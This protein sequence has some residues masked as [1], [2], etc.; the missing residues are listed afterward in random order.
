MAV[1]INIIA[2]IA[3]QTF[4][5]NPQSKYRMNRTEIDQQ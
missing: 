1:E 5:K 4:D 3:Y 2:L